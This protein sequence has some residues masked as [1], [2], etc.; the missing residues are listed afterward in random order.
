MSSTKYFKYTIIILLVL[1]SCYF[2]L[3]YLGVLGQST[4]PSGQSPISSNSNMPTNTPNARGR[5]ARALPP[6][7]VVSVIKGNLP[8]QLTSIGTVSASETV[9]VMSR[10][11]GELISVEFTEGALV[12]AG[13]ILF[14]IDPTSYEIALSQAQGQLLKDKANLDNAKADLARFIRLQSQGGV[15]EQNI[16]TQQSLIRQ[17]EGTVKTSQAL[18]DKA[19]L[20][21]SYTE[22]KAPIDGV[23]SLVD[24][25][26]GNF[27]QSN[28]QI[29][30]TL[31][32][33]DPIDILFSLPER[34]IS[35]LQQA[36]N[37]QEIAIEVW[38]GFLREKL[39]NA[40]VLSINNQIDTATGTIQIKAQSSNKENKLFANQ[41]V[42]VK[43]NL[44]EQQDALILPFFAIQNGA[45]GPFVWR[46]IEKKEGENPVNKNNKSPQSNLAP[47]ENK[48]NLNV[49][50]PKNTRAGDTE[51]L[52]DSNTVDKSPNA[53]TIVQR[54]AVKL[55]YR[56]QDSV[57]ILDGVDAGDMIVTDGVD[58]LTEGSL[59]NIVDETR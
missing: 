6:V 8:N 9:N 53:K 34:H 48:E 35:Q 11:N 46:V 29:L 19:A 13:D 24:I 36:K 14:K 52:N 22:I 15:S 30:T 44:S 56:H 2:L 54:V 37:T 21:L 43:I 7:R 31:T 16:T 39:A 20:E 38:D 25:S 50:Q 28:T 4:E 45:D 40:V 26:V 17:L 33:V 55:G 47:E 10:I 5:G 59:V 3:N 18:Y 41:F 12:K 23:T 1:V 27:V 42:N 58:K 57:V 51:N 32:K 49:Q